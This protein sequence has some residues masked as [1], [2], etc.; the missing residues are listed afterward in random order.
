MTPS[1]VS[2]QRLVDGNARADVSNLE[3]AVIVGANINT[4]SNF[5]IK[6]LFGKLKTDMGVKNDLIQL[7]DTLVKNVT[8]D[9]QMLNGT[10]Y[11]GAAKGALKTNLA[12][13]DLVAGFIE[14]VQ[15]LNTN[16]KG[17]L[18]QINTIDQQLNAIVEKSSQDLFG[19][20]NGYFTQIVVIILI[21]SAAGILI[22]FF[23]GKTISGSL[24][25]L[26][27][28]VRDLAEGDGDLT[29]R[30]TLTSQDETGELAKWINLFVEKLHNIIQEVSTNA[31]SLNRSSS[32]LASISQQMS[33]SARQASDKTRGVA[34]SAEEMNSNMNS[35]AAA[36]EEASTNVS[37]VASSSE[38]MAITV[39]EIAKKR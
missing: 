9:V 23:L 39:K 30:I 21:A 22:N 24:G 7:L 13:K 14:N 34:S 16:E 26:N 32:D 10:E 37:M 36:S 35:V 19:T 17:M 38:E 25:K 11:E 4:S 6:V 15:Q 2:V 8:K 5:Q 28:L 20:I 33:E 29:K 31:D 3:R 18:N 27:H 12:I 1:K